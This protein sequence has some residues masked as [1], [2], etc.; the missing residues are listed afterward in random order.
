MAT[1]ELYA[2]EDTLVSASSGLGFFG[3]DGFNDAVPIGGYNGHTFVTNASGTVESFECNNNK[4][5]G[6]SGV[7]HGQESS[8]IALRQLPNE[9]ATVNVRFTHGSA[10]YCQ[11]AK[12]WVFDGSFVGGV[13]NKEIPAENLTFYAAEIRHKSNR[14]AVTSVYSDASWADVSASGSNY[15]SL[16][17]SP[18]LNGAREGG[19]EELSTQ[20]DWYAALTCTPTQ[21]GDK[22]F[23]MTFELEY[24]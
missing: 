21:L 10:V 6:A 22:Q 1:L 11:Q 14:Q 3:D 9:L 13:A 8:G 20:H 23:G 12:L 7:I 15:I 17:N 19:F 2:G 5:N 24:L 16:V 4:H 18:G